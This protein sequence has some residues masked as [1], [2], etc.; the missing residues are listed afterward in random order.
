MGKTVFWQEFGDSEIQYYK[1]YILIII[2]IK[3]RK[4][5]KD[6]TLVSEKGK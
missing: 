3:L 2:Y 5:L 4:S 6:K 1:L